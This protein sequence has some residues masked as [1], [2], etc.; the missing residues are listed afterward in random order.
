[1]SKLLEETLVEI[2]KLPL[3]EQDA[4][5]FALIDFLEDRQTSRLTDEQ[6]A[7]VKRRRAEPNP[8]LVSH[9]DARKFI[10]RLIS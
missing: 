2:A 7:E 8:V 1:M 4:A 9:E 5:A 3:G 6:L 10:D